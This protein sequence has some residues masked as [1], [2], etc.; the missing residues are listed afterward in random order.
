MKTRPFPT[1]NSADNDAEFTDYLAG[2]LTKQRLQRIDEVLSQR[3]R[4]LTV[5][6]DDLYQTH[7]T[8]ACLRSCESFGVQDVHIVEKRN[9][10]VIARDVDAGASRW[11]TLHR[12]SAESHAAC[13]RKYM[14]ALRQRG[15]RIVATALSDNAIPV[16]ELDLK[17]PVALLFGNEM[18]GLSTEA[19]DLADVHVQVP[20]VGF[21]RS[22]N[23]SVACALVL[24]ELTTRLRTLDVPW[25]LT[26]GEQERL[27]AEWVRRSIGNRLE[28]LRRRY[29]A[30]RSHQPAEE[31]EAEEA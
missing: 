26:A 28:P 19:L 22:F 14:T 8:S 25:Q 31:P 20:M 3:T 1:E 10:Y 2:F 13:T 7:N 27:R 6:L 16:S 23:V 12:H 24:Y 11:L 18:H 21:T 4:W 17:E 5:V 9:P 29:Q 15:C 30:D